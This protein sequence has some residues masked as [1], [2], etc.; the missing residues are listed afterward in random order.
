MGLEGGIWLGLFKRVLGTFG[1]LL[2]VVL[3]ASL[4]VKGLLGKQLGIVM[5]VVCDKIENKRSILLSLK[6]IPAFCDTQ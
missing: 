6:V 4:G 5:V 1:G 3:E 2:K